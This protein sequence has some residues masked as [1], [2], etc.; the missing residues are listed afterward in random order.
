MR[1]GSEGVSY[2]AHKI[3]CK[4]EGGGGGGEDVFDVLTLQKSRGAKSSLR[5]R[6]SQV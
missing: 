4:K 6:Q 1:E 5:G 3:P 2:R